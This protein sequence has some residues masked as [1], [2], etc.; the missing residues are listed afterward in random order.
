VVETALATS[1]SA[2]KPYPA[3]RNG[4]QK[5]KIVAI[6]RTAIE[7]TLLSRSLETRFTASVRCGVPVKK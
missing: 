1:N 7:N 2:S 4:N 5:T 6:E 3:F